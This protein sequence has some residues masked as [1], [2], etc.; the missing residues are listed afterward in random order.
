VRSLDRL[1]EV[2]ELGVTRVG[3][4]RTAAILDDARARL[5]LPPIQVQ[6]G[7]EDGY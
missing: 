5:G 7:A 2:R 6:G 4:S 1:L 3:A